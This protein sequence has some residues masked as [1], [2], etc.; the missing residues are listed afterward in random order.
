MCGFQNNLR[1]SDIQIWESKSSPASW[2]YE[3][4]TQHI[5]L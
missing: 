1:A 5:L 4:T 3:H 2:G